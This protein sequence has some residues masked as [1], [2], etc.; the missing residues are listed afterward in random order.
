M[1]FF[2]KAKSFIYPHILH[3]P[4]II[5]MLDGYYPPVIRFYPTPMA[6]RTQWGATIPQAGKIISKARTIVR[7]L[8]TLTMP[9][10]KEN[11]L[12]CRISSG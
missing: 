6:N 2:S 5:S 1:A 12:W 10:W 7:R 9:V 3:L 11:W 4:L 8:R